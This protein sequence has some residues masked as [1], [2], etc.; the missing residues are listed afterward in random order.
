VQWTDLPSHF[1]DTNDFSDPEVEE[2]VTVHMTEDKVNHIPASDINYTTIP[3]RRRG[4]GAEDVLK[5]GQHIVYKV[6]VAFLIFLKTLIIKGKS[7]RLCKV[8]CGILIFMAAEKK[9]ICLCK[10]ELKPA[11]FDTYTI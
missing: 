11:N 10:G 3:P 5:K 8:A 4:G 9:R 6:I 7:Y 1:I 2:L